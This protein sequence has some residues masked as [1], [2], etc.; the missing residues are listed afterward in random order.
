MEDSKV[1]EMDLASNTGSAMVKVDNNKPNVF[2]DLQS[3]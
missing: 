3:D 1:M 2:N